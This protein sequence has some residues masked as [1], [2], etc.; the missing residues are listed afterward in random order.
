[1]SFSYLFFYLIVLLSGH[2]V[3][4]DIPNSFNVFEKTNG[5]LLCF[6]LENKVKFIQKKW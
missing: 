4:A 3:R 6:R 5:L 2:K 1:M